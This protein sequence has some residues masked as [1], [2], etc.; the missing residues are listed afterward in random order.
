LP[1]GRPQERSPGIR[2]VYLF[3]GVPA[4]SDPALAGSDAGSRL[5]DIVQT[6]DTPEFAVL[7]LLELPLPA[8]R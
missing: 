4:F 3:A 5:R 7:R 8:A 2:A 6:H 1:S